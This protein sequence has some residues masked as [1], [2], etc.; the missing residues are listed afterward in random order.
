MTRSVM[1]AFVA[2]LACTVVAAI[3][4]AEPTPQPPG[5][6]L[7]LKLAAP[8]KT[9]DEAI[10]L[11]NGLLGGLLWGEGNTIRLSLDRGDLW[12][13]RPAKGV[14]WKD[15]NYATMIRLVGEGKNG[16]LNAIFD[17][18]YGDAHPT[19]IPAGRLEIDLAPAQQLQ[20]F[21]LNLASA[22]GR[23]WLADK[24]RL[25]AFFSADQ[26]VALVRI[27]GPAPVALRL[28]PPASVKR[29]GYPAPQTGQD[30]GT[31]WFVQAAAQGLRYCVC[32][33]TRRAGDHTLLAVTVTSSSTDADPFRAAQSRVAA[34]LAKGYAKML[35]PHAAWWR[36]FWGA[37]S[38]SV[39]EPHILRQHYLVQYFYGAASRR[40]APPMPLQ[41]V[42]TAD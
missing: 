15:F 9:W 18:P 29:L 2:A 35:E 20:S 40:G 13:E 38:V 6:E 7:N 19:K 30:N 25:E 21:E 41:G 12:D 10:P 37:S 39:P 22:E 14:R 26:S 31:Q 24:T 5:Q 23:A 42:W 27:P 11:G 16:E 17:R 4:H 36:A 32:V 1:S 3:A 28:R 34:A 33:G 8:I